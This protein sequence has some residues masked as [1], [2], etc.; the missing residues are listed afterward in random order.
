T[1]NLGQHERD[2]RAQIQAAN[3]AINSQAQR[4]RNLSQQQE[5]LTQA[6]NTYSRGIQSAA[7]LAGTGMAA[8][9]TGMYT[10]DKLRQMLGVG[11]EFDATMSA[12]QAV[13]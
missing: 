10:G 12:T 8:R 4:L 3:G 13:T 5:R 2:L 9:A 1:R 6:R 7:A 11:Y